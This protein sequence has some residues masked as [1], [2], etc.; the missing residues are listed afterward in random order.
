MNPTIARNKYRDGALADALAA[1]MDIVQLK[2]DGWW[3]RCV[4]QGNVQEYFSDTDRK[5]AE[6]VHAMPDGVFL[7]E[8]LRGTQWSQR[9]DLK[10]K[11][12]L[13]DQVEGPLPPGGAMILPWSE[14]SYATRYRAMRAGTTLYP[15]NWMVAQIWRIQE[16]DAVWQHYVEGQGYEGLVYRSSKAAI[17][18]D[19]IRDK[20]V[21]TL[22]GVVTEILPGE[23]KHEGRM[24]A[25]VVRIADGTLVRIGNGWRDEDREHAHVFLGKTLEFT[26]NAVFESGNVRHGRF[27][28]WRDDRA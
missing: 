15:A 14:Q 4:S 5:F 24:G 9:E 2:Y 25:L 7:G 11:F 18:A 3:C 12:V 19:I 27:L 10:G 6:S 13:F 16:R 26:A 23:G 21:F 20:R 17:G 22:S 28:R 1:G 8:F